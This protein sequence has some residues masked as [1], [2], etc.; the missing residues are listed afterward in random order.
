M[1]GG[2]EKGNGDRQTTGLQEG[3]SEQGLWNGW[4]MLVP[5]VARTAA[6]M[7]SRTTYLQ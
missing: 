6:H 3:M 1:H 5:L 2:K 4:E 7:D